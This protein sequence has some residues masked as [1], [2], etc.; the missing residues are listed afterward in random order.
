MASLSIKE[1]F[2]ELIGSA[3]LLRKKG[4]LEVS[5]DGMHAKLA[6][7]EPEFQMPVKG[8]DDEVKEPTDPLNNP[9]TFGLPL[10]SKLPGLPHL[11]RLDKK[12]S[13]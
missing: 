7:A 4:I 8:Q 11:M 6:P 9:R 2:A 3:D 10:G 13:Q 12:D 5:F 1:F